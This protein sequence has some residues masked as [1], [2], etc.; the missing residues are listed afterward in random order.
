LLAAGRIA[1]A[2][3]LLEESLRRARSAAAPYEQALTLEALERVEQ[4]SGRDA[5]GIAAE[6]RAI[7]DSLGVA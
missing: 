2:R 3:E 6:R 4:A 5:A 1:E 7:L